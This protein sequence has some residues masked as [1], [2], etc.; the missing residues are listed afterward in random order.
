MT[1]WRTLQFF[2]SKKGVFEVEGDLDNARSV[3]CNCPTFRRI[4]RCKHA[5]HVKKTIKE[6]NGDFKIHVGEDVSEIETLSAMSDK[7]AFRMLILNYSTIE[8]ID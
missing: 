7:E 6:Q 1:D 4:R 8:S 5:T 3:R 2:I